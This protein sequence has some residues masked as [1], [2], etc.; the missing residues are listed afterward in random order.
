MLAVWFMDDGTKHRDTV[1]VSVQSFSRENLQSLRD[2]LLTMG[3]QTTINSDSKG[4]RLYFIKSSYPVFK[5]LVKPYIVECMAYK[6]P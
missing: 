1:D 5:K 3:V 6:L 4:N 2:Q